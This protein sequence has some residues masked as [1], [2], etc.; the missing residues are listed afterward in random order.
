[1][2]DSLGVGLVGFVTSHGYLDDPT[3]RGLR[4]SIL[5]SFDEMDILDMHGNVSRGEQCPSGTVDENVFNI[6]KTGAAISILRRHITM[7]LRSLF[8]QNLFWGCKD[9][10]YKWLLSHTLK[11]TKDNNLKPSAPS[12]LFVHEDLDSKDEYER[13]FSVAEILPIY[14]KGVVTGRDAFVSDFDANSVLQRIKDFVDTSNTDADLIKKYSLNETA[15]WNVGEARRAMPP[16]HEHS[17]FLQDM[18]YRPFDVRVCFYHPSIFMSPRR[19]VMKH[20]DQNE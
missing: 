11:R 18:L 15:W 12:F 6:R 10:K 16:C 9:V 3:L 5:E 17:K 7:R 14:S 13:G 2:I 19:P 20:F 8:I 4:Y 1:M